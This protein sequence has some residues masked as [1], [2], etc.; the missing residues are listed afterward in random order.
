MATIHQTM[1]LCVEEVWNEATYSYAPSFKLLTSDM[2]EYGWMMLG[3]VDITFEAP[4]KVDIRQIKMK[5]LEK[6]MNKVR[7][8]FQV[9]ITELQAQYNECLAIE[10]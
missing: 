3:T 6:E 9:R 10:G 5:A 8:D 1:H 2:S 7:A 4:D